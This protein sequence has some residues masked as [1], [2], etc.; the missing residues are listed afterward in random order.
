MMKVNSEVIHL[1]APVCLSDFLVQSGYQSTR[2]AV[3]LNGEIVPKAQF[4]NVFVTDADTVEIVCFVG[5]G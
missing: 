2:V 5:G 3:E 4:G 1:E